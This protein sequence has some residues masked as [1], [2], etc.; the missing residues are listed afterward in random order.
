MAVSGI[1]V[2]AYCAWTRRDRF[3]ATTAFALGLA[4][5]TVPNWFSYIFTYKG[6]NVGLNG[7]IQ[8]VVLIVEE[9]YLIAGLVAVVLNATLPDEPEEEKTQS[10]VERMEWNQPGTMIGPVAA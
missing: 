8:A 4:S 3:I 6:N 5:L 1:R 10:E 2:L 9:C 7:L